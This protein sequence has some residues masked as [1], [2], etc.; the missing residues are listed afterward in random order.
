[1]TAE[2]FLSFLQFFEKFLVTQKIK[3]PVLLLVDGHKSHTSI[4]AA[5]FL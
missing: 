1:M 2:V 5:V 4:D 3:R